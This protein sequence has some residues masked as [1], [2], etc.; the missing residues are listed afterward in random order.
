MIAATVGNMAL[1][2]PSKTRACDVVM[3]DVFQKASDLSMLSFSDA[4]ISSAK[5]NH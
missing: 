2:S 4:V 5:R 1:N 3:R